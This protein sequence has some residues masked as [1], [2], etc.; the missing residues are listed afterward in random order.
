MVAHH[1]GGVGVAGSN[2][3][4]PTNFIDISKPCIR[5]AFSFYFIENF[6]ADL[7]HKRLHILGLFHH[8]NLGLYEHMKKLI[9]LMR[10]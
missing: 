7:L 1:T 8:V 5:R 4:V 2:P 9:L 3:A 10:G 6:T